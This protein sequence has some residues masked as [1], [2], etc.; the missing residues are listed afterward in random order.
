MNLV[1]LVGTD[2]LTYA[3]TYFGGISY[4]RRGMSKGNFPGECS[5]RNV[6][7]ELTYIRGGNISLE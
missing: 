7:G 1:K 6:E 2:K 5:G 3:V 4:P